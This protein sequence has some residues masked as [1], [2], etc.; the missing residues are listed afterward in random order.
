MPSSATLAL[1]NACFNAS[2]ALCLGLGYVAIRKR[3][4]TVHRIWMGTAFLFSTAFLASYLTRFALY[5]DTPF[6]GEGIVRPVYFSLLISHILLAML[7]LPLVLRT[8]YLA[9]RGDYVRHRRIARIT[10]PLWAY[11]SITGVLIYMML[12]Q[13]FA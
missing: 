3:N 13:W 8:L 1:I 2:S 11:V 6:R 10:F 9:L 4:I 7:T 5:G 12:Y